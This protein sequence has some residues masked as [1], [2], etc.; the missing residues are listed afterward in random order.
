MLPHLAV[1]L[2]RGLLV[3]EPEPE[4]GGALPLGGDGGKED[5]RGEYH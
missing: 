3:H 4:G 5:E 1:V 2:E